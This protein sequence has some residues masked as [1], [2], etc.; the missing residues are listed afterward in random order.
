M[1]ENEAAP[2]SRGKRLKPRSK[3]QRFSLISAYLS[4]IAAGLCLLA[5]TVRAM[6]IGTDNPIFASLVASILFFIGCGVV[7]HVMGAVNL[8]SLKI[9]SRDKER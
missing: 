9:D 8:P 6:S 4:Y 1:P 5:A 7:L 2:S 3:L